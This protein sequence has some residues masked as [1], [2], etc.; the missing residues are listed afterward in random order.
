MTGLDNAK[1]ILMA[2]Y[3]GVPMP[4]EADL[5]DLELYNAMRLL[6]TQFGMLMVTQE[7]AMQEKEQLI[8]LWRKKKCG[9]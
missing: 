5:T 8:E 3:K 6:Y 2:A 9:E 4:P 1:L 7:Q